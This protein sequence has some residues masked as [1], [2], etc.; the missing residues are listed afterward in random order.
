MHKILDELAI[1]RAIARIANEIIE[2][3]KGLDDVVLI[4][5]ITREIGRA[6]V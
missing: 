6:H 1:K 2:S 4:G 3:N 5:I